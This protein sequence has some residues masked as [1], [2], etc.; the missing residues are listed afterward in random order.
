MNVKS[1][2]ST[3]CVQMAI[4]DVNLDIMATATNA[5]KAS[6]KDNI[7]Y[8][9]MV[10]SVWGVKKSVPDKRTL[11]VAGLKLVFAFHLLFTTEKVIRLVK[12]VGLEN[13]LPPSWFEVKDN[14]FVAQMD[15]VSG[16]GD[17][18]T[19]GSQM[20]YKLHHS[21]FFP[22]QQWFCRHFTTTDLEAL[23]S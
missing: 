16:N 8:L 4:V 14:F 20:L 7:H 22:A 19:W 9:L 2:T 11:V 13:K 6:S 5:I 3:R 21:L 10:S 15:W 23:P 1:V 12:N 18:G 17:V